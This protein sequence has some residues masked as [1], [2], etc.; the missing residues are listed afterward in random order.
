MIICLAYSKWIFLQPKCCT[1]DMETKP[2]YS[3]VYEN[4]ETAGER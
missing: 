4:I 2:N 1:S 3:A